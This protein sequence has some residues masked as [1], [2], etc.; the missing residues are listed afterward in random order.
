MH[1][2]AA[3]AA[4]TIV[5][6]LALPAKA[7]QR[8]FV[9]TSGSDSNVALNCPNTAPCRGFTAALTATDAGGEIV[10]LNSGGYGPVTITKSVSLIAPEGVYAGVSVF[11]GAGVTI[12]T[13]GVNVILRGLSINSLGASTRGVNMT[14]G[15]KLLI[16]GCDISNFGTGNFQGVFVNTAAQVR[17][18]DSIFRDNYYGLT[19]SSGAT[20]TVSN[21]KFLGGTEVGVMVTDYYGGTGV[22]TTARIDRSLVQGGSGGFAAQN[23]AAGNTSQVVVNESVATGT[24]TAGIQAYSL[25]GSAFVAVHHSQ[26]V[27]NAYMGLSASGTGTKLIASSNSISRNYYGIMQGVGATLESA[28]D[29][30]VRGNTVDLFGTITTTYPKI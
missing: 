3:L 9:S 22:T 16:D 29:N 8:T 2:T 6:A 25:A 1:H 17:I 20:G 13:A 19:L 27:D 7:A 21:S 5:L 11:S 24:S 30:S 28:G 14:D 4:L 23:L 26:I 15:A 10:A 18:V 12:A